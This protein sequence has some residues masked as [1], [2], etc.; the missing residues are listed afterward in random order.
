[1]SAVSIFAVTSGMESRSLYAKKSWE[2]AR[3]TRIDL[4][5]AFPPA[6][7]MPSAFAFLDQPLGHVKSAQVGAGVVVTVVAGVVV[8]VVVM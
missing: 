5:S 7:E 8:P 4:S 3:L 6:H 1:M 2:R